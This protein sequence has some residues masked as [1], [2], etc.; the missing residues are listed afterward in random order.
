MTITDQLLLIAQRVANL[1][2]G[3]FDVKSSAR[4]DDATSAYM[5]DLR[6]AVEAQLGRGYSEHR[7][8]GDHRLAM[9]FFIERDR[10]V[11][12]VA[13]GLR[14]S[15][16]EFERDILKVLMAR[17]A[18]VEVRRLVFIAKPGG[19]KRVSQA[20]SRAIVEWAARNHQL[21]IAVR[22]LADTS[23]RPKAHSVGQ[24][25]ERRSTES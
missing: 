2:P 20:S 15:N 3:F 9:D 11:I 24:P 18:G 16:S 1:Q 8:C 19:E 5:R 25:K 10:T 7:I 12:E 6:S 21:E 23:S 17:E 13:F 22:D 4:G 14:N